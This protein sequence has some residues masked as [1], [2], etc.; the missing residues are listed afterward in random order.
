MAT[1]NRAST[2]KELVPGLN[3]IFG[4]EYNR[5][6]QEWVPLYQG[7]S[8]DRAFEED[9]LF[10]GFGAAPV[11]NEGSPVVFDSAAEGYVSRYQHETIALAFAITEEA[12]EDNLYDKLSSR[13]TKALARSM[14][15]TKEVKGA[16]TFNNGFSSSF[17]GG[18]GDPLFST[19]HALEDGGSE[20]NRPATDVDISETA[21]EDAM[22][23]I[24]GWVDDRGIPL[25]TQARRLLIPRQLVFITQRLLATELRPDT[26]N[27]DINALR[28][29]GMIP[30]GFSINH[31]LTDI[32]AW[33]MLTDVPDGLKYFTRVPMQTRMEGDFDTGNVR[34]KARERYSFGWSDFRGAW[35]TTGA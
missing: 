29:M 9:V 5:Y 33:F 25:A 4:M 12:M 16:D 19:S 2:V 13:L 10:S 31:R 8:S 18:D 27:N 21:L 28:S 24:A 17:L 30:D 23:Q 26:A 35:G 34:Y 11:K 14:V 1:I 15:H 3:A 6:E 22:I 7:D 20:S 32:D